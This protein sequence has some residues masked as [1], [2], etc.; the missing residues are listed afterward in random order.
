[1]SEVMLSFD[2]SGL[3]ILFGGVL[4]FYGMALV[5]LYT[6]FSQVRFIV[7]AWCSEMPLWKKLLAPTVM[8]AWAMPSLVAVCTKAWNDAGH[9]L[10]IW[11]WYAAAVGVVMLFAVAVFLCRLLLCFT[12]WR[13]IF[14]SLAI[15]VVYTVMLS[16]L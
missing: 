1:M 10:T 3:M 9:G 8:P 11:Q 15:F 4:L 14:V 2:F 7:T 12:R 16:G 5:F 13:S 6:I